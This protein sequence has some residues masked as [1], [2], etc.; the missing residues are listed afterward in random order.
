MFGSSGHRF[1]FG[2]A[3]EP[4]KFL[5][6]RVHRILLRPARPLETKRRS[7]IGVLPNTAHRCPRVPDN[8][9]LVGIRRHDQNSEQGSATR[10]RSKG[11]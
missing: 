1:L 6:P 4:S 7:L 9:P 8:I 3:S 10:L 5:K 2:V 11:E